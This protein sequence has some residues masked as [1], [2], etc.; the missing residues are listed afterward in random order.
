ML[1]GPMC[2]TPR[3]RNPNARVWRRHFRTHRTERSGS[4]SQPL[5]T[6]QD[7]LFKQSSTKFALVNGPLCGLAAKVVIPL[8]LN[9]DQGGYG[10]GA[11]SQD[12]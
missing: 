2:G 1:H 6:R 8:H 12:E 10:R 5:C 9:L 7:D 4:R 11:G 3:Y